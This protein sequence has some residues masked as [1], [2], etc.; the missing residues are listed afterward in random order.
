MEI[1]SKLL[2]KYLKCKEWLYFF[3]SF[4]YNIHNLQIVSKYKQSME[5]V[6]F[7]LKYPVLE[8]YF[9]FSLQMF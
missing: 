6:S 8:N 9:F 2:L 3:V 5:V 4:I 1:F 7:T